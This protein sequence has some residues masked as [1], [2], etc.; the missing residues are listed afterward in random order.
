M[1]VIL[2]KDVEHLGQAGQVKEVKPG[3]ARNYLFVRGL[4]LEA[5]PSL[6]A[7]HEKG[8]ERR[9]V[10]QEKAEA[11][12][13][14]AAKKIAGVSLS[15]SRPV[16]EQGKLFGSVGKSDIVK[17]LKASGFSVVKESIRLESAIK[18]PGDYEVEIRLTPT[19]S[20][21]VK[22]TVVPRA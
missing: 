15:F 10:L 6:I 12:A 5:T 18:E 4:A 17:S 7:W 8:K 14:E 21:K 2:R 16:G 13:Q 20:V 1:K 9:K 3:F 22:V 11:K 19:S